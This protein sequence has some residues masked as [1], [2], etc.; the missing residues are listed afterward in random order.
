[1]IAGTVAAGVAA[2][3]HLHFELA[4]WSVLYSNE[5]SA[6]ENVDSSLENEDSSLEK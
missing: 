1:M 3:H 4:E 2:A 6:I 5:D